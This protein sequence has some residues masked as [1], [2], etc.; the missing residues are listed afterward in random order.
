MSANPPIGPSAIESK[1]TMPLDEGYTRIDL[2]ALQDSIAR[3]T[4]AKAEIDKRLV[5]KYKLLVNHMTTQTA[6]LSVAGGATNSSSSSS[7]STPPVATQATK[8]L[9]DDTVQNINP[10]SKRP[11]MDE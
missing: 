7:S 5:E 9:L 1:L 2:K 4:L 8:S 3:D 11:R 10:N 6:Q